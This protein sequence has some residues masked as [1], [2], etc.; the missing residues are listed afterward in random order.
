MAKKGKN[1][2]IYLPVIPLREKIIFP[3][4]V[5]PIV[6]GRERSIEAIEYAS[7]LDRQVFLVSQKNPEIEYPSAK[8]L[9]RVG[10]LARIIQIMRYPT[11]TFKV[12]IEGNTRARVV[13]YSFH[14]RF[15]TA[16]VS[17]FTQKGKRN[18]P[19]IKA[20]Y[21]KMSEL[22][23]SYVSLTSEFPD[24]LLKLVNLQDDPYKTVDII[25]A[26][27]QLDFKNEQILLESTTLQKQIEKLIEILAEEVNIQG[28]KKQ[29]EQRVEKIMDDSHKEYFLHQQ[30]DA[31]HAEL[32]EEFG[33]ESEIKEIE[34][35]MEEMKLPEQALEIVKRE[36]KK[37][38]RMQPTSPEATV[39]R[40]Y[41]DWILDMPWNNTT[42]D[43]DDINKAEGIL[44]EDHYGL[45]KIK[46]RILEHIAVMTLTER[47]K[48]PILCFVGPP[49]VGKTSVAKSVAKSINR[50]FVR[51]SLG[52]LHDEAEI[53]GHRRTYIGAMP[54]KVIQGLKRA[55]AK[56]PVFL[57]DEIDKIG[58]DFR[59]DPAAAL[60][61]VLDP[62]QNNSFM[63]NYLEI[64]F[65][66]SEIMFITTANT[67]EGIPLP[68]LDRMEMLRIPG[69]LETEKLIIA[70]DFLLPRQIKAHGLDKLRLE[71]KDKAIL[72]IIR[73]YT[74]EA[75]V[76]ELERQLSGILRQI[77]VEVA[78]NRRRKKFTIDEVKVRDY[79][80]VPKYVDSPVPE[81][82]IPG[83]AIGLAWTSSGGELLHIEVLMFPGKGEAK[84]TGRLG[85]IMK[86]SVEAAISLIR[87]RAK[88]LKFDPKILQEH[89]VHF[90]F[91][92][93][94]IPKDGPSAGIAI[95]LALASTLIGK[96]L[97]SDIAMT[98]EITLSGR[99]LPIGGLPEK[100]LAAKRYNIKRVIIP[101]GNEKDL[102]EIKAEITD[103][104]EIIPLAEIDE[105][106][107]IAL[108]NK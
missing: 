20:L 72:R 25:C 88:K 16:L 73:E 79:L 50:K 75:G 86:E 33:P 66:L 102:T 92:E 99:I 98:G 27:L 106:L 38:R 101:A 51:A 37:L 65:D 69:Y 61:E 56:N 46:K 39:S 4:T 31:I 48:G 105:A 57:F 85:D 19:A 1:N 58:H 47:P 10:T 53:R 67:I 12:L 95:A 96:S 45:E 44:D 70:R 71:F 68:L 94:A 21:R 24:E 54:G 64:P 74:R 49:G 77:A 41:I 7:T 43:S 3:G 76:R 14:D 81:K 108:F 104:I 18:T 5:S 2:N 36:I 13:R 23:Q 22:F 11:G 107:D 35:R 9:Y 17:A 90:H 6:I 59:G 26:Q 82:L 8:E 30:I 91:P 84:F 42:I 87:A 15:T 103:G 34:N 52:G 32:G 28:Y 60:M 63:D 40:N 83:E 78:R 62:D 80:G 89:N 29:I 100:L 97:Q 55:G 93:A